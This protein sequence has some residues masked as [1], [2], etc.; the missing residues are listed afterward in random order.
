M[1]IFIHENAQE[2]G[3]AAAA[4]GVADIQRA[5]Q[6]GGEVSIILATGASQ[7]DMLENFVTADIDFSR[8]TAFHL[9]EYIGLPVTHPASFRRYLRERVMDRIP[10]LKQFVLVEG[11]APDAAAEIARLNALISAHH[12]EVCFAGIG[13][14]GHLAFNDPPADFETEVPYLNVQLDE[15]CRLQQMGEGWFPTFDDVPQRAISMGIQQI[16]KSKK[17]ILSVPDTRKAK[18]A[19]LCIDGPVDTMAPASILQRHPATSIHL[20]KTAAS[21]LKPRG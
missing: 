19:A 7:F 14:N 21:L 13:E 12:I 18:A 17:I 15:A 11:D 4:E 1:Q 5:L 2:M 10:T 9:D 8:I 3:R 6:A 20:D 16:L